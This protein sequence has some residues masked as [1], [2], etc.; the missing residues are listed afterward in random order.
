MKTIHIKGAFAI[1]TIC[2]VAVVISACGKTG[3]SQDDVIVDSEYL[4]SYLSFEDLVGLSDSA[5]LGEYVETITYDNYVEHCF[6]VSEVYYGDIQDEQI[7]LYSNK[8]KAYVDEIDYEYKLDYCPYEVGKEYLLIMDKYSSI[9]FTHDR[10]VTGAEL[11]ICPEDGVCS[12]YSEPVAIN[13]DMTVADYIV[14]LPNSYL[15]TQIDVAKVYNNETEKAVANAEYVAKI[16]VCDLYF[17]S[18]THNGNTYLCDAELLYKGGEL[19]LREDG[20]ILLVIL[21]D[22]VEVGGEYIVCFSKVS[23]NSVIYT[24]QTK[25][26]VLEAT[27]DIEST[28][29]SYI[30]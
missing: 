12:M 28:I 5:I 13:K 26:S 1:F 29:K 16:K 9:M 3:K 30:E 8:G 19:N 4:M 7:Y 21:K 2:V 23:E 25:D 20:K 27:D 24:Q 11:L 17:E 14:S 6:K 15:P 10:Y 22:T 18:E